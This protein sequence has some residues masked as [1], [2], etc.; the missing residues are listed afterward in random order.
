[1]NNYRLLN[2]RIVRLVTR[3]K[4]LTVE[5]LLR[6]RK[7]TFTL[8]DYEKG[9]GAKA[10]VAYH[11]DQDKAALVA[12]DLLHYRPGDRPAWDAE[13]QYKGTRKKG[14]LEARTFTLEL[15]NGT[16]NPVRMTITNGPGEPAG[17]T[18][19]IKPK[20]G[21]EQTTVATLLSWTDLRTIGLQ[22]LLH[23]QAWSTMTYYSRIQQETW[24]PSDQ[25]AP[26]DVDEET[27]E[28]P[29]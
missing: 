5:D 12:Y 3:S 15:V 27:G 7:L 16:K 1:M 14:E 10:S 20:A 22:I 8:T 11:M 4:I 9:Q 2:F 19:A 18:G 6:F 24:Q 23:M 13:T 28:I 26:P 29:F 21:E 17:T 25:A